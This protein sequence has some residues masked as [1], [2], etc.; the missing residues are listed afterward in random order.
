MISTRIVNGW[1]QNVWAVDGNQSFEAQLENEEIGTYHGY[2]MPEKDA[3]RAE[4]M[5]EW[6]K[7]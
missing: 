1:P 7:R 6:S 3:F 4:V 2:P 5:N